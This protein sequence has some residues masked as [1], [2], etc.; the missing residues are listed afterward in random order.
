MSYGRTGVR[1]LLGTT[2][3]TD[4]MNARNRLAAF[5]LGGPAP[6]H[7]AQDRKGKEVSEATPR[8]GQFWGHIRGVQANEPMD[9]TTYVRS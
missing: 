3:P 5:G 1:S 7:G 4:S 6:S 8:L 9:T 2:A